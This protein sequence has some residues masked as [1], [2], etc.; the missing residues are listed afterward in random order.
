M[1]ADRHN[2]GKPQYSLISLACLEPMVR[3]LEYGEK[4]YS[5]NNWKKG[6]PQSQI[7]NSTLRHISEMLEGRMIDEESGLPHIALIQCNGMFLGNPNN[8]QDL[9]PIDD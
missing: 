7:L 2:Q 1:T 3:G 6:M 5:R 4:K 8:I 9:Q